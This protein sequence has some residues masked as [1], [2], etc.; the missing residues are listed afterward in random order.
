MS[1]YLPSINVSDIFFEEVRHLFWTIVLRFKEWLICAKKTIS[2]FDHADNFPG[3][4]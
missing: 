1:T 3:K 4:I 2:D